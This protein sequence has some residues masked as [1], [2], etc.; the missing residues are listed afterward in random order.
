MSG[1]VFVDTNVFVYQRDLGERRKQP[2]ARAWLEHLWRRRAG[3]TSMH[4]LG[5]YYAVVTRKLKPGLPREQ[6]RQDVTNLL[7]WNP[8]ATER[9]VIESAWRVEDRYGLSWWDALVVAA[10]MASRC[11]RLLT[12]DLQDGLDLDAVVVVNP[13]VHPPS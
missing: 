5:E 11:E 4:V 10:A 8:I 2:L 3:R 1:N 13:F 9:A 12:E 7:A 6:A